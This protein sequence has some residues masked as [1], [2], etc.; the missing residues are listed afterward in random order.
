MSSDSNDNDQFRR[1]SS[2]S[3]PSLKYSIVL[4]MIPLLPSIFSSLIEQVSNNLSS[5]VNNTSENLSPD[6]QRWLIE[7]LQ[8]QNNQCPSNKTPDDEIE[9]LQSG[10]LHSHQ[11][12]STMF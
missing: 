10:S 7:Q 11:P 5:S 12:S 1:S 6:D 4:V 9:G 3:S 2:N 8:N